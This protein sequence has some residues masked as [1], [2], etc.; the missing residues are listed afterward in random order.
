V[1]GVSRSGLERRPLG[2]TGIHVSVIGLGTVK[3]GRNIGVKYP[4]AFELPSDEAAAGLLRTAID[5]GVNLLDTAPAYGVSEERLGGLLASGKVGRRD[6]WV[7]CTKAGEEFEVGPDGVGRSSFDFSPEAVTASVRR[8]LARLGTDVLDVV[9]LHSGGD[10]RGVIDRS[11]GLDALRALKRAGAIRAVGVST[12]TLAGSL[13]AVERGVDV[14]M[15]TYN[16]IEPDEGP[17]IDAAR[18]AGVGVLVKKALA[19]GHVEKIA[20]PGGQ[21]PV[22]GALRFVFAEPRGPGVSAAVIGTINPRH[23]REAARALGASGGPSSAG[24]P[25]RG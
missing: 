22:E 18:A 14:V 9:L 17:A 10:D 15:L 5:E 6:D 16:A 25:G 7:I 12:K 3:L 21:H 24:A 2:R 11:G 13:L 20:A 1:D 23:L 4:G 8:S 19:S